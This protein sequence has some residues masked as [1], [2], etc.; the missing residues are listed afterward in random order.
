MSLYRLQTTNQLGN[1][2][3]I[4]TLDSSI[5]TII[6]IYFAFWHNSSTTPTLE[7]KIDDTIFPIGD[8]GNSTLTWSHGS[9]S[10]YSDVYSYTLDLT[11][12]S[13]LKFHLYNSPA[14]LGILIPY[15]DA[16]LGD[17]T[18]ITAATAN[19]LLSAV[20][21]SSPQAEQGSNIILTNGPYAAIANAVGETFST[22]YPLK[23]DLLTVATN[24]VLKNT[25]TVTGTWTS[26]SSSNY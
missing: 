4:L 18:F 11:S 13:Q 10:G 1:A 22:P 15:P 21:L 5:Q 12:A 19:E 2:Y 14:S 23:S 3:G 17:E 9:G 24:A 6:Q 26:T 20:S 7:C 16:I 25:W 8:N